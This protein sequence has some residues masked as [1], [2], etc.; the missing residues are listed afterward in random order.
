MIG[1]DVIR[2]HRGITCFQL[3]LFEDDI[4]TSDTN[5]LQDCVERDQDER[6]MRHVEWPMCHVDGVRYAVDDCHAEEGGY[7]EAIDDI[8][9]RR[10][11]D[12]K[13]V[14][15][16]CPNISHASK[17]ITRSHA[18]TCSRANTSACTLVPLRFILNTTHFM[19]LTPGIY[20]SFSIPHLTEWWNN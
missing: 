13:T 3:I 18:R 4:L 6:P 20:N 8:Q 19:L 9:H 7:N 11:A 12:L 1:R 10:A 2:E 15:Q 5:C 14:Q 16:S 17:D